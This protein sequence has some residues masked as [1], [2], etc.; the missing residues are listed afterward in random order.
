METITKETN[1]LAREI[2]TQ[3]R[4][5]E[6]YHQQV[7]LQRSLEQWESGNAIP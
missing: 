2:V 4:L 7:A 1:E 5:E 6:E 3:D